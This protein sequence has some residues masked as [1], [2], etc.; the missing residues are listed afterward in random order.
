MQFRLLV[1]VLVALSTLL[2]HAQSAAAQVCVPKPSGIT[3]WYPAEGTATDKVS[4]AD[5]T[6]VNGATTAPG[7]NGLAFSFDGVNDYV[8]LAGTFGGG[9]QSTIEAWVV[10]T[11]TTADFQAVVSSTAN[12]FVQIQLNNSGGNILVFT[13]T[14]TISLPIIT[15]SPVNVWRHIALAI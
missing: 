1:C 7:Y 14:G 6:F 4:S 12:Q 9:A 15:Q 11:A 13:N 8:S 5:G 10:P 2:L 3:N